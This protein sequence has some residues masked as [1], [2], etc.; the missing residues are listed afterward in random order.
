MKHIQRDPQKHETPLAKYRK[1]LENKQAM[2]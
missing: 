1:L 2:R